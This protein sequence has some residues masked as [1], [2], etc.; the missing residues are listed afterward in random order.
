MYAC[1]ELFCVLTYVSNKFVFRRFPLRGGALAPS[2]PPAC[3]PGLY[4]HEGVVTHKTTVHVL[5]IVKPT[6]QK[7]QE[8]T[9]Q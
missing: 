7:S 2:A 3:A 1:A 5:T 4:E 9:R 6:Q 8:W